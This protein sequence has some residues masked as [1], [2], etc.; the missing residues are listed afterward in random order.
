MNLMRNKKKRKSLKVC[1]W[2]EGRRSACVSPGAPPMNTGL[3]LSV[4]P[5]L[6]GPTTWSTSES[7]S[8]WTTLASRMTKTKQDRMRHSRLRQPIPLVASV[9]TPHSV[10][11]SV[12]TI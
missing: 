5:R 12:A 6:T 11:G 10:T 7:T 2:S 8:S 4:E 9:S 3:V 1:V